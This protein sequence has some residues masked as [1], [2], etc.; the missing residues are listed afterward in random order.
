MKPR[1]T[2]RAL[3][4]LAR[5]HA[6]LDRHDRQ[7]ANR[8]IHLILDKSNLLASFPELGPPEQ[9]NPGKRSLF[10][11]FGSAAYVL[12]YHILK[13]GCVGILR[14]FHSREQR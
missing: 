14:V 10:V 7:A 12:R 2:R 6:F 13:H 9:G 5:L 4:D 1:W 3:L 8:A 11:T